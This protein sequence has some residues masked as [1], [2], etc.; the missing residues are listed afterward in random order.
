MQVRFNDLTSQFQGVSEV[1]NHLSILTSLA[2]TQP[3][4][5]AVP[6]G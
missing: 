3:A 1:G 5:L 2:A 6:S 4:H